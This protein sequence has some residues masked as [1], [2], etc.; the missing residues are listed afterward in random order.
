MANMYRPTIA[1]KVEDLTIHL[2]GIPAES[3]ALSDLGAFDSPIVSAWQVCADD[4]S[5]LGIIVEY[6]A[7]PATWSDERVK[8][9][10]RRTGQDHQGIPIPR[11]LRWVRLLPGA[12]PAFARSKEEA[13]LLF[14]LDLQLARS[15]RES[16]EE[17]MNPAS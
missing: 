8:T 4:G 6:L 13:T 7:I 9:P 14:D 10:F 17:P 3:L 1:E 16:A 12:Q 15:R 5:E 2:S 11:S